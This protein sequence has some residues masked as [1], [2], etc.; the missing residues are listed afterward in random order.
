MRDHV[1]VHDLEP[2][3]DVCSYRIR[4]CLLMMMQK[5]LV[6]SAMDM[7]TTSRYDP[8]TFARHGCRRRDLC[9]F[10]F[11]PLG[12]HLVSRRFSVSLLLQECNLVGQ[13]V[14]GGDEATVCSLGPTLR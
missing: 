13:E 9:M 5:A 6:Q 3:C 2:F 7:A 12:H 4:K 10:E 11:C 1:L 14:V 8:A